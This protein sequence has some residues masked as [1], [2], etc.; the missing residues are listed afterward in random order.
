MRIILLG[1]F[2]LQAFSKIS[3]KSGQFENKIVT[4]NS[5][6]EPLALRQEIV[7][8]ATVQQPT[9]SYYISL[10]SVESFQSLAYI[11]VKGGSKTKQIMPLTR[12][13]DG[14]V[15]QKTYA[16]QI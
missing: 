15:Y 14:Y 4:I 9:D 3:S 7:V 12:G 5:A 11:Q 13:T 8:E 2:I 6:V 10:P 1:T 16:I